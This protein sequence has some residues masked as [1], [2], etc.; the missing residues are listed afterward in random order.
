MKLVSRLVL[1]AAVITLGWWLWGVCF[2]S[3]EKVVA[4]RMA[5]LA[6]TVSFSADAGNVTRLAKASDFP[7]YFSV[8]AEISVDDPELGVHTLSGRDEI[9]DAGNGGFAVLPGLK[10]TF[11]DTT[12]TVGPDKQVADVS[13]TL[14]VVVGN[15]KDYGVQE[16]HFQL[17]K[18]DGDWLITRAETVKTLR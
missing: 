17:K 13:C 12:V 5:S 15:D 8:D 3:V 6:K 7:G 16:M 10:V 14:R 1:L 18:I 9:R 11:L 4:K 2:P